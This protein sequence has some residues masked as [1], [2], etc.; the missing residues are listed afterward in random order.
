MV[1]LRLPLQQ[2]ISSAKLDKKEKGLSFFELRAR[3]ESKTSVFE[4]VWGGGFL[5]SS[6]FFLFFFLFQLLCT[7]K[8]NF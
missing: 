3:T 2:L 8:G 6:F 4:F 1:A 7:R 5:S